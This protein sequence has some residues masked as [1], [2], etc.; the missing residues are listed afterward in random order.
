MNE[1][2]W[3]LADNIKNEKYTK[4]VSPTISE[5]RADSALRQFHFCGR[6]YFPSTK[7]H[8]GF[9]LLSCLEKNPGKTKCYTL[10]ELWCWTLEE[11]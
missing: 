1:K 11:L 7:R 10:E 9:L 2:K 8:L 3:R 4:G 6:F 5:P